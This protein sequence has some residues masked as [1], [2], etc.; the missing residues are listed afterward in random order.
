MCSHVT[1]SSP[2]SGSLDSEVYNPSWPYPYGA[3]LFSSPRSVCLEFSKALVSVGWCGCIVFTDGRLFTGL[4]SSVSFLLWFR[5][6]FRLRYN[7]KW[8]HCI[9]Y[10]QVF[11]WFRFFSIFSRVVSV[12]ISASVQIML[13]AASCL[14]C[15]SLFSISVFFF[16]FQVLFRQTRTCYV[17]LLRDYVCAMYVPDIA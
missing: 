3:S 11:H 5:Y 12:R 13:V 7:F 9:H 6:E 4:G 15:G 16:H 2:A 8:L 14:S 1:I 10:R 17:I